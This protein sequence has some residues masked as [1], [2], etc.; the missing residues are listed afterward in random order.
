MRYAPLSTSRL[1]GF[2]GSTQTLG[3]GGL[4]KPLDAQDFAVRP[5]VENSGWPFGLDC[6]SPYYDRARVTLGLGEISTLAERQQIF[7]G[8]SSLISSDNVELCRHYRLGLH[9]TQPV[10]ASGSV[11]VLTRVT[12]LH[13][14]FDETGASIQA[15]LC[16]DAEGRRFRVV[17]KVF[18]LAAGGIEN[19]RLLLLSN[20]IAQRPQ[21]L[22]GRFFMDHPRFSIGTVRP[23]DGNIRRTLANLDRIRIA[24]NQRVSR[25]LKLEREQRFRVKGLTLPFDIQ[26]QEKLLNHRAWVEPC[27]I[28]QDPHAL[29]NLRLSLLDYRDRTILSGKPS[30]LGLLF[31]DMNWTK[32]MH[33]VR[34]R[35][36]VRGFRLHHIVEPEPY[37]ASAVSLSATRDRHGL[38]LASLSWQLSN[39]TIDSLR[40]TIQILQKDLE[41]SGLGE[42]EITP[43]EWDQLTRPMWTWHHMGTT[44]MHADPNKGVVDANCKVHGLGNLFVAGSSVFPTVGND[45]PTITIVALAHRLSDHLLKFL[46]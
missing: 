44:R 14:E 8:R 7:P 15:A 45:T 26:E 35:S 17:A 11:K 10:A 31:R 22:V 3:W 24:R 38:P 12:V 32:A 34:P 13:F 42:L 46:S 16:T 43:D 40:R 41:S 18:V 2:G 1:K 37:A 39:L 29:E 19:A 36:L 28:G 20:M 23:A 5:W 9:L 6:M 30:G 21:G 4:C 27:Y 25:R 33:I